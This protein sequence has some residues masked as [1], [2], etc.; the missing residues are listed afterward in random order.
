MNEI[1]WAKVISVKDSFQ[2]DLL[3]GRMR[4]AGLDARAEKGADAPGAWLTGS[5][6]PFGPID[7]LVPRDELE[8]ARELVESIEPTA[9]PTPE[10]EPSSG[11]MLKLVAGVVV[12][13]T[14]VAIVVAAISEG[15]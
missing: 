3:V 1:A 14:I 4:E 11:R 10:P 9:R 2:A 5:Q 8:S 6:N 15:F 7:I 12:V 13:A